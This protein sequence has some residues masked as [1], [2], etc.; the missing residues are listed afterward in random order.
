[1]YV[2]KKLNLICF[3]FKIKGNHGGILL[4][5]VFQF[6]LLK[7]QGSATN[8]TRLQSMVHHLDLTKASAKFE[9]A[10]PYGIGSSTSYDLCTCKN[11][12]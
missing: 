6:I 7:L 1:M 8:A 3:C 9:I 10:T 4:F 2:H 12:K 11:S 5:S